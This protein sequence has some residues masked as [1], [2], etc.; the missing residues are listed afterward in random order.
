MKTI[1]IA[2]VLTTAVSFP[3]EALAQSDDNSAVYVSVNGSYQGAPASFN[4]RIAETT[5]LEPAS[6]ALAY[7]VRNAPGFDIG[8]G[9]RVA[10][11]LSIGAAVSRY[12]QSDVASV[13]ASVPHPF[14]FN[15]A[16][17]VSGTVDSLARQELAVHVAAAWTIAA[18]SAVRVAVFGGPSFFSTKLDLVNGA[19]YTETYPYDTASLAGADVGRSSKSAVGFNTGVDVAYMFTP[20]IGAGTIV[21][22]SRAQTQFD[23]PDGTTLGITVGGAQVG[24]G[25]RLR[26]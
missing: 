13:T 22:F 26:F 18:G 9:A 11:R 14:F 23:R 20:S 6:A 10:G 24:A 8:M 12:T 3:T 17:A 1:V 16:R 21:R 2:A 5:N 7:A 4:D 25:L 15:Q 19:N